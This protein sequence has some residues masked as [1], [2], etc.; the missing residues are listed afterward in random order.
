MNT[1][2]FYFSSTGNGLDVSNNLAEI[3]KSDVYFIPTTDVRV[4]EKY[5]RIIIVTP[6]YSLGLPIP[7][8]KFIKAIKEYSD[9]QY[10]CV[11]NYGGFSGNAAHFTQKLFQINNLPIQA[12]YKVKMPENFT[13]VSNVPDFVVN[14]ILKKE[15]KRVEKV[16]KKILSGKR[17]VEQ[18]TLFA[19]LDK[20]HLK[21]SEEWKN[22]AQNYEISDDCVKCSSCIEMC[23]QKNI[24]MESEKPSFGYECV[25]CLACYHRCPKSAI[26]YGD[27]T[28][29]KQRYQ[30][31][32]V[33]VSNIK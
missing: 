13:I 25:A 19:F 9:K 14:N 8:K 32:N 11:L 24:K 17:K 2:I 6:V 12:I 28:I 31:P 5:E 15:K 1:G 26:N 7:V 20:S 10:Y 29:G 27:R 16:A 33:D 23:S 3:I 22:F 21:N 18:Q 30:N 4:L